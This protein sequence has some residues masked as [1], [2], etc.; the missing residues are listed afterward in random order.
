MKKL[1]ALAAVISLAIFALFSA[2]G[3]FNPGEKI[4]EK[5]TE[6]AMEKAIEE[7]IESEGGTEAEV[8]I[9]GDEMNITT[10]EGEMS[11]GEGADLPEGFPGVVPVYPDMQI[12]ASW[13]ETDEE[14]EYFS[15][16]GTSANPGKEINDW[17]KG[18]F[19]SWEIENEFSSTSDDEKTYSITADNGTYVVSVLIIESEGETTL[20]LNVATDR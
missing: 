7:G 9:S 18:Q 5:I 4:A 16:S 10:D 19:G 15:V 3:C 6:E 12:I 17:Y 13:T 2:S 8:D 14:G 20:V 11:F 1:I